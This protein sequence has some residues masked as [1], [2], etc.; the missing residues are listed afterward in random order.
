[1][2]LGWVIVKGS[3]RIVGEKQRIYEWPGDDKPGG[4]TPF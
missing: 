3:V 4:E 1:M 2:A